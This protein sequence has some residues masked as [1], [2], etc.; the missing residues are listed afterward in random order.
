M[1]LAYLDP[2]SGSYLFQILI[3]SLIGALFFVKYWYRK[4]L[5][6]L[7]RIFAGAKKR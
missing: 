6:F 4:A 5:G 3:A 7:R 2:G 1:V